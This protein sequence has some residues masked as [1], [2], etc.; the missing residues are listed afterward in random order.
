MAPHSPSRPPSPC[1][2]IGAA[3]GECFFLSAACCSVA[4]RS[5]TDYVHFAVTCRTI[6]LV[7]WQ[8]LAIIAV[9]SARLRRRK[10]GARC[11]GEAL[12]LLVARSV[13]WS[14]SSRLMGLVSCFTASAPIPHVA[15]LCAPSGAW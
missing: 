4:L 7:Y 8:V 12:G 11:G 2:V 10:V 3:G 15:S 13:S 14:V 5:T 6:A 9:G 1:M